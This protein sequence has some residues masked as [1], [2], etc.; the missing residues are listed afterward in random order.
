MHRTGHI[1]AALLTYAPVGYALLS[2]D[3][4]VLL[5]I[6]GICVLA[7]AS[8]PDIDLRLS[9]IAHR[10]PTHTIVF[11]IIVGLVFGAGGWLIGDQLGVLGPRFIALGAEGSGREIDA[12]SRVANRLHALDERRLTVFGV[13]VGILGIGSHLIA[14]AVTPMG[15]RPFW[16]ISSRRCSF[17]LVKAA[18]PRANHLLFILGVLVT[19]NIVTLAGIRWIII[20]SSY[21]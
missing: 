4:F 1:G 10:G 7:L 9:C 17:D 13:V 5:I 8:L 20:V 14:D 3:R 21:P 12:L 2:A 6:G 15:I 16:P 19:I 18:N 11:A